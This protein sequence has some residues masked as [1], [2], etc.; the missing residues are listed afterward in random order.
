MS[1]K[2]ITSNQSAFNKIL[3]LEIIKRLNR[4][5]DIPVPI[6]AKVKSSLNIA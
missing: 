4:G 6:P 2:Q 3:R 1:N 5:T